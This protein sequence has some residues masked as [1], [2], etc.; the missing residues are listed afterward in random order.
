VAIRL[1]LQQLVA[2]RDVR[3]NSSLSSGALITNGPSKP[4]TVPPRP[5]PI[6][7][8]T[9]SLNTTPTNLSV[10][11]FGANPGN[12]KQ[13]PSDIAQIDLYNINNVYLESVLQANIV[14]ISGTTI[15]VDPEVDLVKL[16][17]ISGKYGIT[18]RF[19][20]NHLG[21]STGD[22]LRIQEISN[23][24]LEIRVAPNNISQAFEDFFGTGFFNQ[25]KSI[26]L[27]NLYI[28]TDP[29]NR[30]G[31]F[32][33]I[34]D[35]LTV[36]LYPYSIILKLT[37]PL[38]D[39]VFIG[40]THWLAQE[41]SNP[42]QDNVVLIPPTLARLNKY[43]AGPNFD[44]LVT[45]RTNQQTSY[46][47][48]DDLVGTD[49]NNIQGIVNQILSGS[50]IEGVNLNIDYRRFDNFTFF[51]SAQERLLNFRYK[52]GLLESYEARINE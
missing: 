29:I 17:Y 49:V 5:S 11:L 36:E 1:D 16:G 31:V 32:D 23:D 13:Y 46:K 37:T 42:I 25:P 26:V 22:K 48:W 20:R 33:Y 21:S 7:P 19:L 15:Q 52:I 47:D 9:T 28:Y 51:G 12:V 10:P 6:R 24:R 18:Y 41:V 45:N 43:I 38:P 35:S 14:S 39:D 40:T 27:P 30:I 2:D 50:L 3:N 44:V 4:S 34:Q 8:T